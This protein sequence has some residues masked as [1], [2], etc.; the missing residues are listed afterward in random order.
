MELAQIFKSLG[1][2]SRLRILNILKLGLFNVQE[3]TSLLAL[4]QPTV[5]HHLKVLAQLGI[6]RPGRDG[7][8]IFYSLNDDAGSVSS[9]IV[10]AALEACELAAEKNSAD[11][12]NTDRRNAQRMADERRSRTKRFFDQV[13][14]DWN[15]LRTKALGQENFVDEVR[16]LIN[17]KDSVLDLGCG[18]GI[19]LDSL[20]P[21]DG[22]TIGIDCSESMLQEC[23]KK[24]SN[25]ARLADLR[26]GYMEHLPVGDET[27]DRAIA[28]MSLHHVPNP[29]EALKEVWRVLRP[30]GQLILVD[31]IKHDQEFMRT[32]FADIWLGFEAQQLNRW[33][34]SC[35]FNALDSKP[36]GK[37]KEVF[38]L[39]CSK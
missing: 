36:V 17:P 25:K 1:D 9:S 12:F 37:K 39:T 31:L 18:N 2:E 32:D 33:L 24:L 35:G 8:H 38:I 4:S 27:V 29:P 13:A 3:L 5:S 26:L 34:T 14:S 23:K 6:I 16:Q 19:L 21:R 10:A 22:V 30:G 11:V 7:T 20:L 15:E 28:Y